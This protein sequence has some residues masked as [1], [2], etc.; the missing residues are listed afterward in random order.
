MCFILQGWDVWATQIFSRE[1]LEK[2]SA[3]LSAY[4]L[5]LFGG[6]PGLVSPEQIDC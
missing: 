2:T 6:G 5:W 3:L 1:K 4:F